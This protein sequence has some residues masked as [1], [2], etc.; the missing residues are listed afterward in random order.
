[1]SDC[2]YAWAVPPEPI[3]ADRIVFEKKAD[4]IVVGAG[5]SGITAA[6]SASEMGL[7]VIIVEKGRDFAARGLHIGVADSRLMRERGVKNDIDEL[8]RE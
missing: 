1:M 5:F 4:V 8:R 7:S 2:R 3:P 6:L